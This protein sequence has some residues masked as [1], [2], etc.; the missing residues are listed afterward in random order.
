MR[1]SWAAAVMIAAA[2]VAGGATQA[3]A[4][5]AHGYRYAPDAYRVAFDRGF[6]D[7]AE[8]GAN[9]ARHRKGF[10]F[11]HDK[12][13]RCGDA[14]YERH[15]GSRGEYAA[16]YRRGYELGYRR[17]YESRGRYRSG[18]AYRYPDRYDER[19]KRGDWDDEWIHELP[20]R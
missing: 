7:G 5:H 3:C 13:Y 6:E 20:R 19:S 4:S 14:G 17:A 1:L 11:A 10:D 15:Y 8:H 9:D 16:G 2:A 18:D 12:K